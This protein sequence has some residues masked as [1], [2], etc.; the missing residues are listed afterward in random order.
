MTEPSPPPPLADTAGC[1]GALVRSPF[2]TLAHPFSPSR[3][4]RPPPLAIPWLHVVIILHYY[5]AVVR[6]RP[7]RPAPPISDDRHGMFWD[8]PPRSWLR[9]HRQTRHSAHALPSIPCP[10]ARPATSGRRRAVPSGQGDGTNSCGWDKTGGAS[11]SRCRYQY[12]TAQA[13][14]HSARIE[15]VIVI[16]SFAVAYYKHALL[17]MLT[18]RGL[19]VREPIAVVAA[20]IHSGNPG[21]R[22]E[23]QRTPKTTWPPCTGGIPAMQ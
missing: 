23:E 8:T 14:A 22:M 12:S 5:A 1:H 16:L 19:Q 10:L 15:R 4:G 20:A 6:A 7:R 3:P 18:V 13:P 21:R 9:L 2:A 11:M 17:H